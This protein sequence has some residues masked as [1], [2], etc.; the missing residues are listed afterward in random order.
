MR[1]VA[2]RFRRL[3]LSQHIV[4]RSRIADQSAQNIGLF[5][6]RR[7]FDRS[8]HANGLH[9]FC[10]LKDGRTNFSELQAELAAGRQNRLE[11]YAFDLLYLNGQDLR[12]CSQIERK[13]I[14]R[15]LLD[16]HDIEAP[17][18][19]SEHFVGDGTRCSNTQPG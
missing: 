12:A 3:A 15:E 17:V 11:L 9:D 5:T 1:F 16:A 7:R 10:V 8:P 14:L 19:Y 4:P 18:H 2:Q 13:R 6:M